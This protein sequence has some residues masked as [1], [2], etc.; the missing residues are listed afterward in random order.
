MLCWAPIGS[1]A[2][3]A[4]PDWSRR[5]VSDGYRTSITLKTFSADTLTFEFRFIESGSNR[6]RIGEKISTGPKRKFFK[7]VKILK[8]LQF[9]G[10][11]QFWWNTFGCILFQIAHV[12]M[13][14]KL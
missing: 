10:I 12:F 7:N 3:S 9:F 11:V 13:Q 6:C 2:E 5:A 1:S 8:F 14:Q 4:T